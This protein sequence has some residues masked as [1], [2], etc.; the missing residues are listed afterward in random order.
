ME[1]RKNNYYANKLSLDRVLW[2]DSIYMVI[3]LKPSK[4]RKNLILCVACL[5][6]RHGLL[7]FLNPMDYQEIYGLTA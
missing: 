3:W 1:A 2:I 5:V 7:L 6:C 4:A